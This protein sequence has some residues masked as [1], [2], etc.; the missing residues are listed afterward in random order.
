[1]IVST[2]VNHSC[3]H[4]TYIQTCFFQIPTNCMPILPT[5]LECSVCLKWWQNR[6]TK[7][8]PY[9]RTWEPPQ[10]VKKKH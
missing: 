6:P 4:H 8:K 5:S 1:M 2:H 9:N 7:S 10:V 3:N